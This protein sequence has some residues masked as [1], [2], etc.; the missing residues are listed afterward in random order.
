MLHHGDWH[1]LMCQTLSISMLTMQHNEVA[2][3][4][5]V[6]VMH[7]LEHSQRKIVL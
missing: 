6:G 4:A 1:E 7:R 2:D 3:E 5:A